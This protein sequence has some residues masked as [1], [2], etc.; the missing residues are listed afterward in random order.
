MQVG[1]GS[2]TSYNDGN[3]YVEE[4]YRYGYDQTMRE[5]K[6]CRTDTAPP[7]TN[8]TTSV[9]NCDDQDP[10]PMAEGI[11]LVATSG[12]DEDG[13]LKNEHR[14]KPER[15]ERPTRPETTRDETPK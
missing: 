10:D 4:G 14:N 1:N 13:G 7:G 12:I 6:G 15:H 8:H 3:G 9:D 5:K 2:A 11:G